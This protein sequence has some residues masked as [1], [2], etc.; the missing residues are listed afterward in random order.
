MNR[1]H[2]YVLSRQAFDSFWI[3]LQLLSLPFHAPTHTSSLFVLPQGSSRHLLDHVAVLSAVVS[4]THPLVLGSGSRSGPTSDG[5]AGIKARLMAAIAELLLL[6]VGYTAAAASV[7]AS[8]PSSLSPSTQTAAA[9]SPFAEVDAVAAA[10]AVATGPAGEATT[11][12]F[13][14]VLTAESSDH[15]EVTP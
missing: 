4:G 1:N 10:A 14:L 7:A 2:K 5:P 9:T 11:N 8:G 3:T 13:T 15:D 12:G 6:P